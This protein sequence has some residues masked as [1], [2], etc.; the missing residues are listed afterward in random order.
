MSHAWH[1]VEITCWYLVS[2]L[3]AIWVGLAVLGWVAAR[4]VARD[5]GRKAPGIREERDDGTA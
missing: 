3:V 2:F 1:V 4:R 5:V